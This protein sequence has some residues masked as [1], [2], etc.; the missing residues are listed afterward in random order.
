MEETKTSNVNLRTG[1]RFE[2]GVEFSGIEAS[3]KQRRLRGYLQG[4]KIP[5]R[6]VILQAG[7][8]IVRC[9]A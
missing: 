7:R 6:A 4:Y 1:R 5:T 2:R 3:E 8:V 9:Q